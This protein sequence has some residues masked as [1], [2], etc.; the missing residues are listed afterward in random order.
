[1]ETSST[2]LI[3]AIKTGLVQA[4]DVGMRKMFKLA[5]TLGFLAGVNALVEANRECQ[6]EDDCWCKQPGLRQFRWL[7]PMGHKLG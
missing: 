5:L 6:C 1:M 4:Y 2:G 3:G 7:I